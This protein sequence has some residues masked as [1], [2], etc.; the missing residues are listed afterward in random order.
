MRLR[1]NSQSHW[2]RPAVTAIV[3]TAVVTGVATAIV[4]DLANVFL[5][6]QFHNILRKILIFP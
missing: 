1:S 5:I 2:R 3:A 6:L 4:T